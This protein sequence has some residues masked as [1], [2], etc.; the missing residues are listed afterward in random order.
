MKKWMTK[1]SEYLKWFNV[2]ANA[3]IQ[4]YSSPP[5]TSAYGS[6]MR[7]RGNGERASA[8][9][10]DTYWIGVDSEGTAFSGTQ[11]NQASATTW[12]RLK[13]IESSGSSSYWT[14][15]AKYTDGTFELWGDY[16][17]APTGGS[18]YTTVN[19]F[20][21]YYS[22]GWTFP[23]DCKPININYRVFAD[24]YVGAGFTVPAGTANSKGT[25]SFNVYALATAG[26]QTSIRVNLCVIGRWK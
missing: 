15:W 13:T 18:H 7:L 17:G 12:R 4:T 20:Y 10:L 24:W 19:G 2:G 26:S 3:Q 8:G 11:L 1:V 21:G 16:T 23:S 22:A 9:T 6:I 25:S 14:Y 5:S